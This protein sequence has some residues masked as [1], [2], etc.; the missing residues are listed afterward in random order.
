MA[1]ERASGGRRG[2]RDGQR[3]GRQAE[4]RDRPVRDVEYR[5]LRN[6]F[7]PMRVYSDDQVAHI[8]ETALRVLEELGM[9]V[10]LPKARALFKSAGADVDEDTAMVRI[11]RGLV[12]D[13]LRT[14]PT[15]FR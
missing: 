14:A 5:Q 6:P 8:H 11:D 4:A 10:L 7:P 1:E 15:R 9:R 12:A 3:R 2:R 13:A